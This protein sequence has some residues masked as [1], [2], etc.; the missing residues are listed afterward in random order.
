LIRKAAS[1]LLLRAALVAAVSCLLV[2]A[3]A[4]AITNG[5]ATLDQQNG[6]VPAR[7]TIVAV[8]D[9]DTSTSLVTLTFPRG[10]DLKT[11]TQIAVDTLQG[12][13]V[14]HVPATPHVSGTQI[15]LKLTTPV[16]PSS[17]LR[18]LLY[19]VTTPLTGGTYDLG[20]KYIAGGQERT[21]QPL[22]F[23]YSTP[24]LPEM[25]SR[26]L[27]K[28]A[29][30]KR[31]NSVSILNTFFRPQMIV[32][33]IFLAFAGWLISLALVGVAFPIAIVG[34]L[35][36]AFLKMSKVLPLS[37]L[38]RIY[39]NVIRG[40]PLFLQIYIVYIGMPMAGVHVPWFASGFGV[41]ALN[42]S[43]YLAEIFR[44]GIQS[45]NRGQIEAASSLGM[46]YGQGMRYVIIPQTVRRVLPTMTSEFILLFKDTS[47]LF[48]VGVFE[49]MMYSNQLVARTGNLTPFVVAAGFYLV[50]TL[51][52]ISWVAKLEARLAV[53]EGG[54]AAA[55]PARKRRG[56]LKPA[57]DQAKAAP[58][59]AGGE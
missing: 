39:I 50:V 29:L 33:G 42:S 5:R 40:T 47:L 24:P 7:F 26:W 35:I 10:F 6:G 28:Q 54:Q 55:P 9:A 49:L 41:L 17:Q 34:G 4:W 23:S 44:A 21:A 36:L 37:L 13:Q 25:V 58:D 46:T 43:A 3:Q 18:V 22:Q 38:A 56:E 30:V 19:E 15:E 53:S 2:P 14:T 45:I 52:L 27:D 16:S 32:Q 59:Q 57:P 1:R 31:W 11:V 20:F 51:P 48:A 12:V 8:T